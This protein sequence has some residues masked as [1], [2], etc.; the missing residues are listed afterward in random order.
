MFHAV[1]C[2]E[3]HCSYCN[4][5]V[6]CMLLTCHAVIVLVGNKSDLAS[7]RQVSTQDGRE[8]ADRSACVHRS[9]SH[10][11]IQHVGKSAISISML[12]V[13]LSAVDA[14]MLDTNVPQQRHAVRGVVGQN[15]GE[16]G[17]DL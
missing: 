2:A 4:A 17:S 13:L 11:A 14:L 7:E 5:H 12:H 6:I 3:C 9:L 15:S 1:R 10:C 16:C 8:F